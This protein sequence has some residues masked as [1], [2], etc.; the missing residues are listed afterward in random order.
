MVYRTFDDIEVATLS[1]PLLCM[2]ILGIS[3]EAYEQLEGLEINPDKHKLALHEI[4]LYFRACKSLSRPAAPD[5]CLE[6]VQNAALGN[7]TLHRKVKK[8]EIKKP[9]ETSNNGDRP[10]K[11]RFT[12]IHNQIGI[13]ELPRRLGMGAKIYLVASKEIA[14]VDLNGINHIKLIDWEQL[15][16]KNGFEPGFNFIVSTRDTYNLPNSFKETVNRDGSNYGIYLI[17][18]EDLKSY[19]NKF[20]TPFEIF[21]TPPSAAKAQ[22]TVF[23]PTEHEI[24][25]TPMNEIRKQITSIAEEI[26]TEEGALEMKANNGQGSPSMAKIIA[27]YLAANPD[28]L[29]LGFNANELGIRAALGEQGY[30]KDINPDSLKAYFYTERRKIL[31]NPKPPEAIAKPEPEQDNEAAKVNSFAGYQTGGQ[32]KGRKPAAKK[33]RQPAEAQKAE[34]EDAP[35]TLTKEELGILTVYQLLSDPEFRRNAILLA[36]YGHELT[37]GVKLL[38]QMNELCSSDTAN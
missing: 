3:K 31:D 4:R 2:I 32:P 19:L 8:P 7:L 29:N 36:T 11:Q 20:R 35:F 33:E 27:N 17:H 6:I 24:V 25:W 12:L 18:P 16:Q 15:C 21:K 37:E 10:K 9:E 34:A 14:S 22:P 26:Q 5:K 1:D 28:D 13:N 38:E 23:L 30:I